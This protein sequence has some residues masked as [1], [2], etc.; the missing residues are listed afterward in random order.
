[1]A[2]TVAVDG[3]AASGKGTI[4]RRLA[5]RFGFAHLDTGLLYRA[6]AYGALSGADPVE[7]AS[8]L[9]PD[10]LANDTRLRTGEVAQEASKVAVMPEVRQALLDF[11]RA[12]ARRSGGAVLDGRDIGTVI[13]PEAEVKLYVTA[14]PEIRATRRFIEL[15]GRG[16]PITLDEVLADV[17]ARDA[18]DQGRSEAPMKPAET[19]IHIDTTNMSIEDA[20][21]EAILV[22]MPIYESSAR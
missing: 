20:V 14:S 1:M 19:A 13:C 18:R 6:V 11:Q 4:C 2:F 17:K 10:D 9:T 12:F 7:A 8:N 16:E 15:T 3:P 21:T 5:E 22:V